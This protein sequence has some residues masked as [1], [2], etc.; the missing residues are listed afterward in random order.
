MSTIA[1]RGLCRPGTRKRPQCP[2]PRPGSLTVL[3]LVGPT[4]G[5]KTALITDGRRRPGMPR[6]SRWTRARS[7]AAWT[8]GPQRLRASERASRPPII[9]SMSSRRTRRTPSR[10]ISGR[11]V[12]SSPDCTRNGKLPLLVGGTGLYFRAVCDG[13]V[14]PPVPPQP[15]A[16]SRVGGT[17]GGPAISPAWSPNCAAWT[18][19]GP[20]GSTWPI[21]AAS[22]ARWR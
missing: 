21:R 11:R 18:R 3:A 20:H 15:G 6:S 19:S 1:L 4:A 12:P 16:T 5:G 9:C 17:G 8:S 10:Y 7:T 13:L 2:Q 22:S 14:L